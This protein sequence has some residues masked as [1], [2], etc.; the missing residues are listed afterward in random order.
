MPPSKPPKP[1]GRQATGA[2]PEQLE[3]LERE[4]EG[5]YDPIAPIRDRPDLPDPEREDEERRA[6][7]LEDALLNSNSKR[8]DLLFDCIRQV[9]WISKEV[10]VAMA[11]T[12]EN[13]LRVDEACKQKPTWKKAIDAGLIVT[14]ALAA[15]AGIAMAST[16]IFKAD[17]AYAQAKSDHDDVISMKTILPRIEAGV[18]KLLDSQQRADNAKAAG[19]EPK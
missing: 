7:E 4:R 5:F 14:L 16:A 19:L 17:E 15:A 13:R 11:I 9:R 1:I 10:G 12:E 2:T 8:T 18:Q 3:Q 6:H